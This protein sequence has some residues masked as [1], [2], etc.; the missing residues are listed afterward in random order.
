MIIEVKYQPTEKE[1]AQFVNLDDFEMPK[2]IRMRSAINPNGKIV[3][4]NDIDKRVDSNVNPSTMLSI[5]TSQ[6]PAVI[7]LINV[8]FLRNSTAPFQIFVV[9][10]KKKRLFREGMID[11]NGM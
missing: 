2:T 11:F 3:E 8:D 10:T 6:N 4:T 5:D 1:V 9:V 7:Q